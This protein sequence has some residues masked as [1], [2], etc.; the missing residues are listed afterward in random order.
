RAFLPGS[1][2]EAAR[3][4]RTAQITGRSYDVGLMQINRR[5]VDLWKVAPETLLD[6]E[7]NIRAGVTI[8]AA[9]IARHGFTWKAVGRYHSPG[10]ER[11][12]GYAW[13]IYDTA[14]GHFRQRLQGG[15]G[16]NGHAQQKADNQGI[17]LYRRNTPD[18]GSGEPGGIVRFRLH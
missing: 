3:I 11:G 8:L 13:R 10:E 14:N 9:E 1:A 15:K 2:E 18:S 5:W 6:P 12:L 7:A 16:G 17:L 4:I